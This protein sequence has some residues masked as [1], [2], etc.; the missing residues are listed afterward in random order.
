MTICNH[1]VHSWKTNYRQ[2]LWPEYY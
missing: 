2:Y 1:S